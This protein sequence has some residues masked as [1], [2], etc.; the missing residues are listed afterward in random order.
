MINFDA[1][2]NRDDFI[3]RVG[4]AARGLSKSELE[5][6]TV[7]FFTV[8]ES[9]NSLVRQQQSVET[10][11]PDREYEYDQFARIVIQPTEISSRRYL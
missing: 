9:G 6:N 7:T 5:G 10:F 3:H 1:P 4:R 11:F 8:K 2:G